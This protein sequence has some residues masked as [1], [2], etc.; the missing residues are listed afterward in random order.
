MTGRWE[1]LALL[2]AFT[3]RELVPS[4]SAY[5]WSLFTAAV[6]VAVVSLGRWDRAR[7]GGRR[8]AALVPWRVGGSHD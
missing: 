1:W 4:N 3:V 5:E 6:I 8:M 7:A 2:L